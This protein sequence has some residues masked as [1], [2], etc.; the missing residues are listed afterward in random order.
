[1]E[2]AGT[3]L[4]DLL[5]TS[6]PW[7]GEDCGREQCL[8]DMTKL[9]TGKLLSQSCTRRSIVY[10]THCETCYRRECD[11]I[12]ELEVD[13]KEKSKMKSEIRLFIYVGESARSAYERLWEQQH[14]LDQLNPDSHMLKHI[15]EVH[16]DEEIKDIVFHAKVIKFTRSAFER[17]ILE[18][19]II[20]DKRE[21]NHILNSKSEYN[22]CS[23]PRLT[24]KM[25]EKEI[26]EWEK[27]RVKSTRDEN[28]KEAEVKRKIF[29]IRKEK[30]KNRRNGEKDTCQTKEEKWMKTTAI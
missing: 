21:N 12:D 5:H 3:K 22:R 7:Q 23:L 15:V 26:K 9:A 6:N 18:S 13:D 1:M 28:E 25:G 24:T 8:L 17:Q 11:K 19:V 29:E 10:Q 2:R 14:A 27:N 16:G 20:Q 4:E 30:M